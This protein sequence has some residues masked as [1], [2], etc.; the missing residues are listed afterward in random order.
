MARNDKYRK[1][2]QFFEMCEVDEVFLAF[3]EIEEMFYL[4][5]WVRADISANRAWANTTIVQSFNACWRDFGYRVK[6]DRQKDGVL[7]TKNKLPANGYTAKTKNSFEMAMDL[8]SSLDIDFAVSNIMKYHQASISGEFTRFRSWIY[9]FN[10]FKELKHNVKNENLLCL[11]LAWYM[12]SWG[13]LRGKSFL[14]QMDYLIHKPL[15]KSILTGKYDLLYDCIC[16]SDSIPLTLDFSNEI[17]SA[18]GRKSYT[19]TFV[20]KL[21]LGIF[22]SAPAYDRFFVHAARKYKVCSGTWNKKSLT[23]LWLYYEHYRHVFDNLQKEISIDGI[24][25]T[26]M[27]LLDM[28]LWQ[29]GFDELDEKKDE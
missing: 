16:T 12:A 6:L 2:K 18:Y 1:N 4:P 9:C 24:S 17:K 8:S 21:I 22:G 20:T 27:K 11:H 5:N 3:N 25:Y 7:F 26:P 23:S 13:M 28:C 14:L 10:A 15:V 29:I 19:D